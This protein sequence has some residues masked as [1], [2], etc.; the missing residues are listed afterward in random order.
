M[1]DHCMTHPYGAKEGAALSCVFL[2]MCLTMWVCFGPGNHKI[3]HEAQIEGIQLRGT[4]RKV[5][6]AFHQWPKL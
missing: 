2:V 4:Q 5:S 1:H 6:F 3:E